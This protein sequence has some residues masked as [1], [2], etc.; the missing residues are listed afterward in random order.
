MPQAGIINARLFELR[1]GDTIIMEGA[2]G[3]TCC[4]AVF[5]PTDACCVRIRS[6]LV[7]Q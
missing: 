2:A 1:D 7:P 3:Q 5:G 6:F 4:H